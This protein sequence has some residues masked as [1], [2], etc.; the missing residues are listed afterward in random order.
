MRSAILA[1][2]VAT[3]C[4]GDALFRRE[5]GLGRFGVRGSAALLALAAT[6]IGVWVSPFAELVALVGLFSAV[7]AIAAARPTERGAA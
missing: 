3:Y 7:F 5:L 6:P 1:G 2:G 4:A